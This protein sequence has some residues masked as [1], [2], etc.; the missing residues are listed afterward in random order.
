MSI[1][2]KVVKGISVK[3][4]RDWTGR[5]AW[6]LQCGVTESFAEKNH[7]VRAFGKRM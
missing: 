7:Q 6:G 4:W 3:S 5:A 1:R 2:E